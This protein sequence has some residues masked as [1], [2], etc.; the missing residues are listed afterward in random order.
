MAPFDPELYLRLLGERE[1]IRRGS[2]RGNAPNGELIE[3]ARALVEVGAIE[4]AIASEVIDGY[5]LAAGLRAARGLWRR[6]RPGALA[7]R[8]ASAAAA[9]APE[10]RMVICDVRLERPNEEIRIRTVTLS[11]AET[12]F[13]VKVRQFDPPN[14]SASR[15]RPSQPALNYTVIDDRGARCGTRFS[16]MGSEREWHGRLTTDS[17]LAVDTAW[18]EFDGTRFELEDVPGTSTITIE[19]VPQ[20]DPALGYLWFWLTSV[21]RHF[22]Q[23][24]ATPVID[25]LVAAGSVDAED[26]QLELIRE[27][28]ENGGAW[29]HGGRQAGGPQAGLGDAPP[30]WRSLL[31]PRQQR[32]ATGSISLIAVTPPFDGFTVALNEISTDNDA[33]TLEFDVSPGIMHGPFGHSLDDRRLAWWAVDDLGQHYLGELNGSAGGPDQTTGTLQFRPA[34]DRRAK[35]LTVLPTGRHERARIEFPLAWGEM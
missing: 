20:G 7:Q 27:L 13:A 26:P 29:R 19:P 33:W 8:R 21:Q 18:I 34:I 17:P 12:R 32:A 15:V 10:R 31:A 4:R 23:S 25:A 9:A 11:E 2:D 30:E 35:R 5:D 22:H 16:G 1:L 24:G 14:S 6:N 28:A 3:A